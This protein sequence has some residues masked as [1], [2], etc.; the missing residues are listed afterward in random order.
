MK[1]PCGLRL[2]TYLTWSIS[3]KLIKPASINGL[4]EKAVAIALS[5]KICIVSDSNV[6]LKSH[7]QLLCDPCK[8][9]EQD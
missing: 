6:P 2:F 8:K 9:F 5:R 7:K 1:L 4:L 3:T